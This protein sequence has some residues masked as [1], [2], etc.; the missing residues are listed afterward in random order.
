MLE[1]KHNLPFSKI[2]VA[3]RGE[4]AIRIMRAATELG[5][6]TVGIY[7]YE[8]RF[9][10]HRYKSDESYRI[11]EE[12][13]PLKAYLDGDAVI[14]VAKE[15]G[16]EAIHP[17]YGLLSESADFARKCEDAGIN[18]IGPTSSILDTFGDKIKAKKAAKEAGISILPGTEEPVGSLDEAREEASRIGFPLLLKAAHGGGGKGIRKIESSE[19]L[20]SAFS[21]TQNEALQ[22]FRA[23][24]D[25]S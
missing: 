11:G 4:I 23:F 5:L 14:A 9:S 3:N 13:E 21:L 24:R 10:L 17:G 6:R 18:F 22:F 8:D 19:D 16:A 2:L 12:G 7:A 25:F 1:I 20:V 15:C